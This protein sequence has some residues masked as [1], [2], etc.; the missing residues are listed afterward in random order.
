MAK[1]IQTRWNRR[2]EGVESA[3]TEKSDSDSRMGRGDYSKAATAIPEMGAKEV[4][5]ETDR[6]GRGRASALGEQHRQC[7]EAAWV[8]TEEE[9]TA[10][11]DGGRMGKA[12]ASD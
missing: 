8:D 12:N 4:E 7:I 5:A 10:Y 9:T 1:A 3:A 11:G 6:K 2:N